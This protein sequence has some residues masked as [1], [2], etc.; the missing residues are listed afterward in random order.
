MK[1]QNLETGLTITASADFGAAL[2]KEA[3]EANK[4]KLKQKVIG[5]VGS[6]LEEIESQR[7]EVEIQKAELE[8]LE[9]MYEALASGQFTLTAEGEIQY[10]D[11]TITEI[12][13]W[14]Y[15]CNRCGNESF[16]LSSH[17]AAQIQAKMR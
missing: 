14:R 15:R 8:R 4:E 7:K 10:A 1:E 5:K 6:L 12:A 16:V 11:P 17:K 9:K 2:L 13:Q 3:V